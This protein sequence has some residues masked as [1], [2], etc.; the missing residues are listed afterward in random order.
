MI[1]VVGSTNIDIHGSPL[2]AYRAGDSNPGRISLSVGGVGCNIARNLAR[3]GEQVRFLTALGTDLL[4]AQV[5]AALEETT[6]DLSLALTVPG[7]ATSSYLYI[8]DETGDMVSAVSDMEITEALSPAALIERLS[9]LNTGGTV[10]FDANLREDS[11]AYIARNV[12]SPLAADG[13]SV[14]KVARLLPV[15]TRLR[16]LKCNH[17]EA[18][19]LTGAEDPMEEARLLRERGVENVFI[20]LGARGVCCAW[21]GGVR[22]VPGMRVERVADA[23]GVGDAFL[24]GAV[25]AMESGL[26]ALEAARWGNAAAAL[27]CRVQGTVDRTLSHERVAELL[28]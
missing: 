28:K 12:S 17:L 16:T 10:V 23:T 2:G 4:S 1:T 20:T 15:L 22:I 14:G 3:L 5:R 8:T 26:P 7:G 13:V 18:G 11:I 25:H 24:A 19:L 21:E 27:T 9:L 6:L